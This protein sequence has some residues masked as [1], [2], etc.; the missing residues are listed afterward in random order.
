MVHL[1]SG[2]SVTELNACCKEAGHTSTLGRLQLP[3]GE[4]T[5]SA[6]SGTQGGAPETSGHTINSAAKGRRGGKQ[7]SSVCLSE[8]VRWENVEPFEDGE[9]EINQDGEADGVE[10]ST[11][12]DECIRW[13]RGEDGQDW[14]PLFGWAYGGRSANLGDE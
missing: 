6:Y 10:G 5:G 11:Q 12:K 3:A 2:T 4:W 13:G 8:G 7:G 9:E 1:F 14:T